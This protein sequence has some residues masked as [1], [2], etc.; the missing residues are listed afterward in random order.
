MKGLNES[1][2]EHDIDIKSHQN[3]IDIVLLLFVVMLNM[4]VA[5]KRLQVMTP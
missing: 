3:D 5:N 4:V 1:H 2:G